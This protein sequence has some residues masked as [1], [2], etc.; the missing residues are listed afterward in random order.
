MTDEEADDDSTLKA[1]TVTALHEILSIVGGMEND[2]RDADLN[3]LTDEDRRA[4]GSSVDR[5]FGSADRD[6]DVAQRA[7]LESPKN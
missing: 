1:E 6:D 7:E 4:L 2:V 3:F 5:L